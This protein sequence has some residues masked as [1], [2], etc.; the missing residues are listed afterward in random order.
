MSDHDFREKA[1]PSQARSWDADGGRADSDLR[2][3]GTGFTS[4][5]QWGLASLLIG[6]TLLV[7][8]CGVLVFNVL[9]FRTG[10]AGIPVSLALAG[11]LIGS[12]VVTAL[13]AASLMF[14]MR[15][16]QQA[17]ATRSSPALGIAGMTASGAGL[18]AWLIAAIDLIMILYSFNH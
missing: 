7:A 4:A 10:P 13:G 16:W 12:L 6:C 5:A 2:V 18:V 11:G 1:L 15:G 9:L 3:S 14:G 8:A 17:S